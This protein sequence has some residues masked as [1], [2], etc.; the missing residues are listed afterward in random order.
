LRH[1]HTPYPRFASYIAQRPSS[2]RD[3]EARNTRQVR[4]CSRCFP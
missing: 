2:L 4:L 3:Y 1:L